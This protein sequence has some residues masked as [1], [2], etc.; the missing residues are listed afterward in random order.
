MQDSTDKG[1]DTSITLRDMALDLLR[2]IDIA[3]LL[4]GDSNAYAATG[5]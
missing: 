5:P 1:H 4:Q 3:Y 2:V